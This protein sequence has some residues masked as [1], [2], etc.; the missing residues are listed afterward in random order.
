[1]SQHLFIKSLP[2]VAMAMGNKMGVEVVMQGSQARTDGNT[3]YLPA[4]PEGDKSLWILARGYIDHEAGHI[5]HTDFSHVGSTPIHRALTNILEDIRIELEMGGAYP[6]CA[7]NL[8]NLANH[9]AQ[10]GAFTPEANRPEQLLPAWILTACRSRVLKQEALEPIARKARQD[11]EGLLGPSLV[12]KIE[13]VLTGVKA[14]QSTGQAATMAEEILQL[15]RQEQ[16]AA[17]KQQKN[18][19]Q[20]QKSEADGQSDQGQE[21]QCPPPSKWDGD[22]KQDA[23]SGSPSFQDHD[24]LSGSD[25]DGG[26]KAD[27]ASDPNPS[28]CR[29]ALRKIL[30]EDPGAFGDIGAHCAAKLSATSQNSEE[31]ALTGIYPG[32]TPAHELLSGPPPDLHQVRA[33]TVGLRSRLTR[34][35]QASRLKRSGAGRWGRLVDHRVLHRLPTSDPRI[36]RRK[37]ERSAIHTAVFILLDRSGSM[38]GPRIGLAK[39]A[40]LALADALGTIPGV[41]VATA[42]FPGTDNRVVPLTRFGQSVARSKTGY[43]IGASGGTPLVPA[44][45]WA[46]ARM[47]VRRESRKIVL[48]ATDGQPRNPATVKAMIRKLE[49]EGIEMMGLGILDNG[50][51]GRY[52]RKNQ[53]LKKLSELPETVFGMLRDALTEK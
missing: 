13:K 32:E 16:D 46:R 25:R 22:S 44:L 1:M 19:G 6:G 10:E 49:A 28:R 4:L 3:I 48:V 47:A 23:S 12:G 40:V 5:R 7:V 52:F 8:R 30:D 27:T 36:F 53:T 51:T 38:D 45:G 26:E 39:K 11:L 34:L 21:G 24:A 50:V 37:E 42:A 9:L 17:D 15:L 18:Q 29:K 2:V 41:S 20:E 33:E 31:H 43:G 35:V 14:L